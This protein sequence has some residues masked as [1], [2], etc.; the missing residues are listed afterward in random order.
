MSGQ[1]RA[2]EDWIDYLEAMTRKLDLAQYHCDRLCEFLPVDPHPSSSV[3]VQAEFEGVLYAFVAA[4]DQLAEVLNLTNHLGLENPNLQQAL[5]RLPISPL[6]KELFAWQQ[7]P[8]AADVR[9]IR[10]RAVHHHYEKYPAGPRFEVQPPTT[11]KPY[12][13]SRSLDDYAKAATSHLMKLRA[14]TREV[15]KQGRTGVTD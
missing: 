2:G 4:S 3:A 12:G 6:R 5:E 7:E 1:A 9:N 15:E 13:G 10:R 14:L 11:G 8:I